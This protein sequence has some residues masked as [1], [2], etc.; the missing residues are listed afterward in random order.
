MPRCAR[1]ARLRADA[2]SLERLVAPVNVA[3]GDRESVA[4]TRCGTRFAVDAGLGTRRRSR[5]SQDKSGAAQP[6]AAR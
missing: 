6:A 4:P 3:A 2:S 1:D 5:V